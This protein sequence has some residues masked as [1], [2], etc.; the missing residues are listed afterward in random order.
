MMT[1]PTLSEYRRMVKEPYCWCGHPLRQ[2]VDHYEHPYGW[3][4]A[5]FRFLQWLF[6]ICDSCGKEWALWKLGVPR[7]SNDLDGPDHP[8]SD[9]GEWA[10]PLTPSG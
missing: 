8:M 9:G 4:V 3:P 5:G 6:L 2:E 7:H 10:L 1:P